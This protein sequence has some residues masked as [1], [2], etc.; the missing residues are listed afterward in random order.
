MN[1]PSAQEFQNSSLWNY[2]PTTADLSNKSIAPVLL[3][4]EIRFFRNLTG[5]H[6]VTSLDR[7]GRL[8][9]LSELQ[10][11]LVPGLGFD[12]GRH[13]Q[14]FMPWEVLVLK[15]AGVLSTRPWLP[16]MRLHRGQ[17]GEVLL[18]NQDDTLVLVG[19]STL[20]P[21]LLGQFNDTGKWA[22]DPDFGF[23]S[24]SIDRGGQSCQARWLIWDD[25]GHQGL[26][27]LHPGQLGSG[28]GLVL[29]PGPLGLSVELYTRPGCSTEMW[30]RGFALVDDL[31]IH[32]G[33]DQECKDT[34]VSADDSSRSWGLLS[35]SRKLGPE[36]FLRNLELVRAGLVVPGGIRAGTRVLQEL[37]VLR[38]LLEQVQSVQN[39]PDCTTIESWCA[40]VCRSVTASGHNGFFEGE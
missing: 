37:L 33:N 35:W 23:L 8:A 16:D 28:L 25:T 18:L 27:G 20:N 26:G 17:G 34:L 10:A 1:L 5:R 40:A 36:E 14:E 12:K 21:W 3:G 31:C 29:R 6:F 11:E 32:Y 19:N 13:V 9:L 7:G 24:S 38:L 4:R 39:G 15:A 30:Q 22:H 2:L